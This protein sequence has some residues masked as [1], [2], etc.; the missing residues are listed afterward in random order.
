LVDEGVMPSRYKDADADGF[1]DGT[2]QVA[3]ADPG[4]TWYLS[5][6]LTAIAG[7]CNDANAQL[8]PNTSRYKDADTDGVSDGTAQNACT[9]PGA[10][11]Y[12]ATEL[13]AIA[14]DCNDTNAQLNPTTVRY[15]DAD[16][17]GYSDGTSVTQC[18]Q[19]A[20]HK[21]AISLT[22][23]AGDC[24]DTLAQ[25]NPTTIWYKD[26]DADGFSD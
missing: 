21:L 1:S 18:V 13:T 24:N 11:W 14:G 6:Q 26:A 23:T 22:A 3:C 19:P 25:F 2:V 4:A 20:N 8:N 16:N 15:K 10:T 7:D 9:D 12:L 17:D 5:T